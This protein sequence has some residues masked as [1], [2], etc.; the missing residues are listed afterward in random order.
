MGGD[1]VFK[2]TTGFFRTIENLARQI[3]KIRQMTGKWRHLG[4]ET[5]RNQQNDAPR[6]FRLRESTRP[7]T[8]RS[9]VAGTGL[10]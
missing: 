7:P 6:K 4:V 8:L 2:L 9:G 1:A 10:P 5:I 3:A